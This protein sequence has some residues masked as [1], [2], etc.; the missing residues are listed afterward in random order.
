MAVTL[1]EARASINWKALAEFPKAT[2]FCRCGAT[3]RSHVKHTWIS[4]AGCV[5]GHGFIGITREPCPRCGSDHDSVSV[6]HPPETMTI[7]GD[8]S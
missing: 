2:I 6:S 8:G 3:F 7:L 1:E 4:D 5:C